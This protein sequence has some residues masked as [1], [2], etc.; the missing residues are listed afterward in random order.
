MPSFAV[1]L[2]GGGKKMALSPADRG[3]QSI[4]YET[5]GGICNFFYHHGFGV[6]FSKT[7]GLPIDI[8]SKQAT[9]HSSIA[10]RGGKRNIDETVGMI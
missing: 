6:G 9:F 1:Q 5:G 2:G 3:N 8:Q 10:V 4:N 7:Y